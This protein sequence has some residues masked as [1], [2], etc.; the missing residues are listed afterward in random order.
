MVCAL[1][2]KA[3]Y[4]YFLVFFA[5]LLCLPASFNFLNAARII[6]PGAA[7]GPILGGFYEGMN[8]T[9]PNLIFPEGAPRVPITLPN[10]G[11]S[12]CQFEARCAAATSFNLSYV[13]SSIAVVQF[14]GSSNCSTAPGAPPAL[15]AEAVPLPAARGCVQFPAA[16]R[17]A[18]VNPLYPVASVG[19]S[20]DGEWS[21]PVG[22]AFGAIPTS[23]YFAL[24]LL[25][26]LN[27]T[28]VLEDNYPLIIAPWQRT[29][30]KRGFWVFSCVWALSL[31]ATFLIGLAVTAVVPLRGGAGAFCTLEWP[32]VQL[33]AEWA[34]VLFAVELSSVLC[35]LA[36][37]QLFCFSEWGYCMGGTVTAVP[38]IA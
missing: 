31:L 28:G 30:A 26:M 4:I 29:A 36:A 6:F 27:T 2:L 16:N 9:G 34:R 17:S 10:D 15:P 37:V 18:W 11:V 21:T 22:A 5:V 14:M 38:V 33:D 23:L 32:P 12:R 24:I 3:F 7:L 25:W 13:N 19:G 1:R 8:C 20:S 35:G